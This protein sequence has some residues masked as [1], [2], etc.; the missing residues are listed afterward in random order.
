MNRSYSFPVTENMLYRWHGHQARQESRHFECTNG[1]A[2]PRSERI[3]CGYFVARKARK[4]SST[5]VMICWTKGQ[6]QSILP[7]EP[8]VSSLSSGSRSRSTKVA[9]DV[10]RA[11]STKT[12]ATVESSRAGSKG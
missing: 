11:V 3:S 7:G 9:S 1:V 4:G 5:Q 8:P 2:Q 12:A 6:F 10:K